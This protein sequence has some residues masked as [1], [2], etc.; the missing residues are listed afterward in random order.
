MEN[1][2]SKT[3]NF[4]AQWVGIYSAKFNSSQQTELIEFNNPNLRNMT[5]QPKK[6]KL[7]KKLKRAVREV[8]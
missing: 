8:N 5:S 7:M 2:S 6:Q 4:D 1:D 3:L